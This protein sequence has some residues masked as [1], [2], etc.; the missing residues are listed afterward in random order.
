[1]WRE[2]HHPLYRLNLLQCYLQHTMLS[3]HHTTVHVYRQCTWLSAY[4]TSLIPRLPTQEPGNEAMAIL[5]GHIRNNRAKKMCKYFTLYPKA[6]SFACKQMLQKYCSYVMTI[7]IDWFSK[8]EIHRAN[9][10][11]P[12]QIEPSLAQFSSCWQQPMTAWSWRGRIH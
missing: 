9:I 8:C 3:C 12:I 1:M 6:S 2:M 5:I 11:M 4:Y 10:T 7:N